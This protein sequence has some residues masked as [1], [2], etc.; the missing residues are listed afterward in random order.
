MLFNC[1]NDTTTLVLE[2]KNLIEPNQQFYNVMAIANDYCNLLLKKYDKSL[3]HHFKKS[4]PT[5]CFV[6]SSSIPNPKSVSES[7]QAVLSCLSFFLRESGL[8]LVILLL[9]ISNSTIVH[10]C[11]YL[12]SIV[13]VWTSGLPLRL[14]HLLVLSSSP[15]G[16]PGKER[17][18]AV[19]WQLRN[20]T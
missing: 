2:A 12:T 16:F 6:Y 5:S 13:G 15:R 19:Y 18:L 17:L 14:A 11:M 3:L 1:R 4:F 7:N 10:F 9:K 8:I 20:F